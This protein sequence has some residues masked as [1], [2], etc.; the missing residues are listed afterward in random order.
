MRIAVIGSGISG[1]ASAWLLSREHAVTLFEAQDYLGGHTHTHRIWMGDRSYSVD[2][3]F[4]VYNPLHYP[5]LTRLFN[6]LGVTSQPTTMSFSVRNDRSGVEYNAGSLAG[7]FCQPRNLFSP[8]FLGMLRDLSRFYREAPGVLLDEGDVTTL[9]EYLAKHRYGRAF[10]EDHLIPMASALWS[11]APDD[12]LQFPTRHLVQFMRNHQMFQVSGRAP[13]CVVSGG[14]AS[15]VHAL[16]SSWKVTERLS[17]DVRSVRRRGFDVQIRTDGGLE[18]F[19]HV[20]MACHSDQALTL[21]SDASTQEREILGAI[22]YQHN[23]A[24]LH[25]DTSVLP[26]RLSA[27]AAWNALIPRELDS[28]CY[29]S[30][31]MNMLQGLRAPETF[32]V[33]LNAKDH[34]QPTRILK[35]MSYTHPVFD[36]KAVGAQQRK[37]EIQGK[38]R[39][40][41]AG[42]YWGWG[43]HEDGMRSAVAVARA[44][45]VDW[46]AV[47]S[48][49]KAG[50]AMR[51]DRAA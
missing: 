31:C 30:Y 45:G 17:S 24:I 8:R 47:L 2:S 9:G 50:G 4:I 1:L 27:W 51:E 3:G 43:F 35:R 33:S 46:P 15:Y 23:E 34:I 36:T 26:S 18:H 39:T 19:D 49:A 41:Y 21:L 13:W 44:L 28:T 25:T 14:S 10:A 5:L 7:L 11:C 48:I 22:G 38:R 42:A 20:V 40:W 6:E 12:I 16:R 29:V 32:I 37:G